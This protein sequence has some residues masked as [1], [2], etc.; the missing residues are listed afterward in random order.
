MICIS[1]RPISLAV[2]LIEMKYSIILN[3]GNMPNN[4]ENLTVDEFT[5]PCPYAAKVTDSIDDIR[6]AMTDKGI[7]H[8]PIVDNDVAVG[9]I[10]Q[11]DIN[12]LRFIPDTSEIIASDIMSEGAFSVPTGTAL[13]EVAYQMSEKKIGSVVIDDEQGNAIGIFTSTDALNALVEV[14]RGEI[15]SAD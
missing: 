11:R 14:L 9:V 1:L 6:D 8:I 15:L 13:I 2:S 4:F 12:A 5:S 3:G 7:R 10:S